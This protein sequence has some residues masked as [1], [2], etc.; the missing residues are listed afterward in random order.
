MNRRTA[1]S[2]QALVATLALM[3]LVFGIAGGIAFAAS[4]LLDDQSSHRTAISRDLRAQ[5]VVSAEVA[6]VAGRGATGG[7][8]QS[9]TIW[10]NLLP[11]GYT[12]KATCL[13]VDQVVGPALGS[14]VLPWLGG[15]ASSPVPASQGSNVWLFF[16]ALAGS[17]ITAWVDANA[18]C[19]PG[20]YSRGDCKFSGASQVV[21]AFVTCDLSEFHPPVV[22]VMNRVPSPTTIRFTGNSNPTEQGQDGDGDGGGQGN[23]SSDGAGSIYELFGTTPLSAGT[24]EE[25]FVF[26][27]RD[28]RTTQLLAL[29]TL[30]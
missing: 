1:Q 20:G 7:P 6:R 22:H 29:G 15:C 2:G 17:G 24:F 4:T 8:C 16:N 5:D 23:G 10:N 28:G 18:S 14:I 26:V 25:A 19:N 27:S 9:T 3:V 30:G 12:S 21:Q 13:R 11:E